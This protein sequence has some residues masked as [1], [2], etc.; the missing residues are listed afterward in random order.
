M[1][2]VRLR[3]LTGRAE[4]EERARGILQVCGAALE[5]LGPYGASLAIA[6]DELQ[7]GAVKF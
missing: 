5:E 4:F 3:A 2:F 7:N 1:A 6:A